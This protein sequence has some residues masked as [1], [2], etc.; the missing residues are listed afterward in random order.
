[1]TWTQFWDMHS[2]GST[3]EGPYENIYIEAPEDEAVAIFYNRFGHDP[4]RISCTCCGEDYA[5]HEYESLDEATEF[6]REHWLGLKAQTLE[7]YIQNDDV[8]VIR[9]DEIHDDER[10][11]SIPR[12]GWVWAG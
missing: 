2:G 7:E 9:A 10:V 6:H 4:N 12:S 11:A 3:K 8:L 5:I 1:M